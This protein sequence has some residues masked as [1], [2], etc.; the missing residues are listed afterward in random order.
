MSQTI[1]GTCD[2]PMPASHGCHARRGLLTGSSFGV[3]TTAC[4]SW[5]FLQS[6]REV[7]VEAVDI[8]DLDVDDPALAG[9]VDEPGDLEAA[10]ANFSA[11]S[12][13][14]HQPW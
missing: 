8:S 10:E 5:K 13:F 7:D 14:D 11:I 4:W 12:T 1:C 6:R 9:R 3:S 2:A